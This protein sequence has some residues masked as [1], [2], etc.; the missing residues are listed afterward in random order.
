[1]SADDSFSIVMFGVDYPH[2]ESIFPTTLDRVAELV[3][4]PSIS[5]EIATTILCENA[6]QVYDF[7]L[8]RLQ[9]DI[10]QWVSS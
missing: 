1:M 10:D 8:E 2:F 6:A 3:S 4:H 7:D 9:P 5:D